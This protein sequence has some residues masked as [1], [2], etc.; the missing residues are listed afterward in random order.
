M[1]IHEL[2]NFAG[3]LGAGAYLAVDDGNDTGKLSTQQL[4]AATEARIDNIIAGPAP[5]AEEI[6]DARYGAD[7]ETYPSLGDAIRDQ[8]TDLK[9]DLSYT[10]DLFLDEVSFTYDTY[11]GYYLNN[12][13]YVSQDN[14]T[15][16][17]NFVE[18]PS[19]AKR[20][21]FRNVTPENS[22]WCFGFYTNNTTPNPTT[23]IKN[24]SYNSLN[25][26]DSYV[27]IPI[28][29]KYFLYSYLASDKA[30]EVFF[31]KDSFIENIEPSQ[32]TFFENKNLFDIMADNLIGSYY[33]DSNV[34]TTGA[35]YGQTDFIAVEE[36]ERYTSAE[37]GYFVNLYDSSKGFV[38]SFPSTT[39]NSQKYV[40]IPSGV[41]YARFMF[42]LADIGSF[43]VKCISKDVAV[44]KSEYLP[45]MNE[46]EDTNPYK[47]L[48][49]VAFGTSLTYKAQTTGGYLQYLPTLSGITFDNQGVGSSAILNPSGSLNMLEKIKGYASYASK[50]IVTIEGFVNDWYGQKPLG[51]YTDTSEDTVC[52]CLRSAINYVFSQ[53]A[54][55]TLFIIL[56]HYGRNY[57][58]ANESS[59][60]V[61]NGKTQYEY[62]EEM[63]KVCESLGV[64]VIKLY[65]ISEM[66][67][68]TPQYYL[69]D[70]HPNALGAKQTASVIWSVMKQYTPNQK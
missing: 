69:D 4:L 48:Q 51:T 70:I 12:V 16:T 31:A 23:W 42:T 8:V 52:G 49:G 2:N 29:A 24:Y 64:K 61:R 53:N 9:D 44:I 5:S 32:T 21:Y 11:D 19:D 3:T 63:A 26:S 34:L 43:Y 46:S 27:E 45:N 10:E 56:D 28:G 55:V 20:I 17:S 41:A 22:F 47:D 35:S 37:T 6:V 25:V 60:A 59:T 67:E 50:D 36:A 65:A 40:E 39:Y 14:S 66:S 58:G 68:N 30:G 57:G 18:I 38:S 15:H 7:G 54:N 62:Y 1:Q 33:N 13:G